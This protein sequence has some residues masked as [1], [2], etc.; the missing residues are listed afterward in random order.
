M[1]II[2]TFLTGFGLFN[3]LQIVNGRGDVLQCSHYMPIVRPEGKALPCVIYCHGNRLANNYGW[4]EIALH[5]SCVHKEKENKRFYVCKSKDSRVLARMRI[6]RIKE[7]W[8]YFLEK[9]V[10]EKHLKHLRWEDSDSLVQIIARLPFLG[11]KW[12]QDITWSI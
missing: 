10:N 7:R 1:Y 4:V 5:W 8:K 12:Y 9:L 2:L 3:I 6:L 11:Y